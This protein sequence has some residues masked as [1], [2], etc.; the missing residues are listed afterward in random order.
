MM[1]AWWVA[2]RRSWPTACASSGA[3]SRRTAS[4]TAAGEPGSRNTSAPPTTPASA[5]DS[6][7]AGP[8]SW[9]DSIAEQLAEAGQTAVEQRA[10]GVGRAIARP[11][12]GSARHDDGVAFARQPRDRVAQRRRLL[13]Q[14]I[15]RRDGEPAPPRS[16]GAAGARLRWCR[17]CGCRTRSPAPRAPTRRRGQRLVVGDGRGRG[18]GGAG[19]SAQSTSSPATRPTTPAPA[20]AQR[21]A[22]PAAR[23]Q[24]PRA[25]G[26]REPG[27]RGRQHQ[28]HVADAAEDH[29]AR[30]VRE[31]PQ[32]QHHRQ[33]EQPTEQER[34]GDERGERRACGL[35]TAGEHVLS[36]ARGPR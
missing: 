5:R 16:A 13:G 33:A 35:S 19:A 30:R 4:S 26:E 27:D 21:C 22:P 23:G 17:A 9:N 3:I 25:P 6:I 2:S 8:M 12:T 11:D 15:V 24:A 36:M 10:D 1:P 20:S 14:Q 31:V 18:H 34:A 32:L 28:R 7:A 29:P